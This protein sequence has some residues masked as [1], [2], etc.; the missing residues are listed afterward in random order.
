[1]DKKT[2]AVLAGIGAY[3]SCAAYRRVKRGKAAKTSGRGQTVLITGA[4]SGIGRELAEVFARRRFDLVL[5]A[6]SKNRL[7]ELKE[8]LELDY[9]VSVTVIVK[10]LTDD[11]AAKEIYE[12]TT[13]KGIVVEQLVNNAGAGKEGRVIDTEPETMRDLIRMNVTTLT[14]LSHYYGRDMAKRGHGRI[15]NVS[16]MAALVPDPYFNVYGPTKA[17]ELYLTEAM[18]GELKGTGVTVTALC[19]G[20]TK[21]NWAKNA[22]KADSFAAKPPEYV[23]EQ[24]FIG[25]QAGELVVYPN[26]DFRAFSCA[27]RLLPTKIQAGAVALW[28]R[29]LIKKEKS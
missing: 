27:M 12:E 6:R 19:P 21:T 15:L 24:A 17:Y 1:M 28:Q 20:P 23:A 7:A 11:S 25:M 5:V 22:G 13:E 9:G 4:S 3:A 18:Y 2:K 10:D 8:E 29:M 14:L 26:L 16:S